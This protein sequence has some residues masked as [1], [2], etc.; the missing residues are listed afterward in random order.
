MDEALNMS[1]TLKG[2][3]ENAKQRQQAATQKLKDNKSSARQ[4]DESLKSMERQLEQARAEAERKRVDPEVRQKFEKLQGDNATL[5]ATHAWTKSSLDS[6]LAAQEEYRKGYT[7]LQAAFRKT[8][9]ELDEK[10]KK[11]E[12]AREAREEAAKI[13]ATLPEKEAEFKQDLEDSKETLKNIMNRQKKK[14]QAV[15]DKML[16]GQSGTLLQ[17]T[18]SGWQKAIVDEK[19]WR[20]NAKNLEEA[21]K[22]LKE[23]QSKKKEDASKVLDRMSAGNNTSLCGLMIQ[24]WTKYT[25]ET[26][27]ERDEAQKMQD[28][29]KDA[30]LSARKTLEQNLAGSATGIITN[31]MKAWIA[32]HKEEKKVNEMKGQAES[33]L[34]EYQAKK[35]GEQASVIERMAGEQT[36][37]LMTRMFMC[38]CMTCLDESAARHAHNDLT[39]EVDDLESQLKALKEAIVQAEEDTVDTNEE[40]AECRIKNAKLREE[41]KNIMEVSNCIDC[42]I[43]EMDD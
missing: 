9:S 16:A 31:V 26:K 37:A 33:K 11:A 32:F 2:R 4:L 30:K 27:K 21:E 35:K 39:N 34:K 38:W 7:S 40:I 18:L 17:I 6:T 12:S 13:Y 25:Q 5:Q 41:F 1:G 36:Q 24:Y 19:F 10:E 29:M 20:E 8:K 23:F 42:S 14:S 28:K 22:R 3:L 43:K 15:L